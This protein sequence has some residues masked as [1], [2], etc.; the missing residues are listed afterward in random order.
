MNKLQFLRPDLDAVASRLSGVAEDLKG[1]RF[2][3]TGGTGFFGKWFLSTLITLNRVYGAGISCTVLTRNPARFR[4]AAAELSGDLA[5]TLLQGDVA[6][7]TMPANSH[8]THVLHA[9]TDVTRP[10]R[11]HPVDEIRTIVN[12]TDRVMRAA[13]DAGADSFLLLGSGAVYGPMPEHLSAFPEDHVGFEPPDLRTAYG[14]GKR[15]NEL[16]AMAYHTQY[17]LKTRIARCFAFIGP[18]Q[19]LD[20]H[21]AVT[22]FLGNILHNQ[23]ITLSGTGQA[24]R[25]YLYAADLMV[26]LFVIL[27]R[28]E[29]LR[30]Y[31]VGSPQPMTIA[32]LARRVGSI[33]APELPVTIP[34]A[35]LREEPRSVYLPDTGRA[36]RELGLDV[37]TPFDEAVRRT[38]AWYQATLEADGSV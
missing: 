21:F 34:N 1:A 35:V 23:P 24:V 33:L 26:W 7:F 15:M 12:G 6:D 19:P 30:P 32:E 2:F 27:V 9:A 14:A 20:S 17:G 10:D 38:F 13:V 25:S 36:S 31:N 28:G 8:F 5:V 11:I 4:E 22:S 3:I 37:W 18:H 29:V 16:Q